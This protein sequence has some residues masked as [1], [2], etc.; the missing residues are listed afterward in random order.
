MFQFHP[1]LMKEEMDSL[2]KIV[3]MNQ[4]TRLLFLYICTGEYWNQEKTI[5][6]GQYIFQIYLSHQVCFCS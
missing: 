5:E 2:E 6:R 4:K 1:V 3:S